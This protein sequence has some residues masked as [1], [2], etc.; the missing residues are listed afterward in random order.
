MARIDRDTMKILVTGSKGMLGRTMC[1]EYE[2]IGWDVIK[3]DKVE[4]DITDAAA[5]E[6]FIVEAKPEVVVHAAAMADVDGCE[7]EKEVAMRVNADG[8]RNVAQAVEKVGAKIIYISTDYV[9]SGDLG[10]AYTEKDSVAPKTV[11]GKSKLA[12]EDA[13]REECT[14]FAICRIAWLYGEGGPSF[15]HTMLRLAAVED[16]EP[17]RVIN[18][19]RGNPTSALAVTYGVKS[20]ID[21]FA[22]GLFHLSC[23]GDTTW[24]EF[25][26]EIARIAGL[27][28]CIVPCTTEEYGNTTP[29]PLDSRLDNTALSLYGLPPM[30]EWKSALKGFLA[31]ELKRMNLDA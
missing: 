17:M 30:P 21:Q 9:F 18:D 22:T 1:S 20:I 31:T 3:V 7:A 29:R 12:G 4:F 8:T 13:I 14:D 2:N 15:V 23:H 6:N 16:A 5:T 24:Y 26:K 25:A 11:Y 19:Q 10:R 27:K 28:R